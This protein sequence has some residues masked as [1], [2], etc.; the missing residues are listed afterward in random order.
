[1]R[2]GYI[3][4]KIAEALSLKER[5]VRHPDLEEFARN[6]PDAA[7]QEAW[8]ATRAIGQ[9][10]VRFVLPKLRTRPLTH[11]SNDQKDFEH[12]YTTPGLYGNLECPFAKIT[13]NGI[14][15]DQRN[16]FIDPIAAEFHLDKVSVHS[17]TASAQV[18]D[19]C[20]IRFLDQHSPEEVAQY[21]EN[22][23]HEIPRSHE[24]CVKR[25]QQ[26]NEQIQK[27]DAKYGN[28]VTMLQGLGLKHKQYLPTHEKGE[29]LQDGPNSVEVVEKWA[30]DISRRSENP[31]PREH[32]QHTEER[33]P[34]FERPL[35]EIRL[36]ESPSRPWGIPVP[37]AQEA[38]GSATPSRKG[39]EP[40][41]AAKYEEK[42]S[43]F[44]GAPRGK[45]LSLTHDD[46][47]Q[48]LPESF[49][50]KKSRT[51]IDG[52]AH[53]EHPGSQWVFNGPVFF[54]CSPEQAMTMM[55]SGHFGQ[56]T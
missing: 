41:L 39:N 8:R 34:H 42:R 29:S 43:L 15:H 31:P 13:Q 23:K 53:A 24:I 20:P 28:L 37:A 21:F 56:K 1:M 16:G 2:N 27:L 55:Q 47:G 33:A 30:E 19:K 25:Y 7:V 44:K 26:N 36:G 54:G 6:M 22:H 3:V 11:Q 51:C 46:P 14:N 12:D 17:P 9:H 32:R 5:I 38:A 50:T 4:Q 52:K 48:V 40:S 35:R 10:P 49:A 45:Q 18:R